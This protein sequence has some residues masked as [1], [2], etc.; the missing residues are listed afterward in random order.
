MALPADRQAFLF[1]DI[2]KLI[3]MKLRSF[4]T[5]WLLKDGLIYTYPSLQE[6]VDCDVLIVGGGIT[7]ALMAFQLSGEGYKTILIDKR[8]VSLG[9]TS[10]TTAMIQYELDEPLHSLIEKV[11]EAAAVDTYLA[12]VEAIRQ[13]DALI[14]MLKI[15]CGFASKKSLFVSRRPEHDVWLKKEYECRKFYGLEVNRLENGD[16]KKD[17]DIAGCGGLLSDA[18]ASL[19]AYRLAH[20]LI[21]HAAASQNLRVYDHTELKETSWNGSYHSVLTT[22]LQEIRCVSIVYATGF[23]T[24]GFIKEKIVELNSTFACVSEPMVKV[25]EKLKNTI[26]WDTNDPYLYI[27]TTSDNR[28]L[29]GGEDELFEHPSRRDNMIDEKEEGLVRGFQKL[30]PSMAFVPDFTWAG[31]FGKTKDSLPY[32]GVKNDF[33]NS[34]FVLGF[35]GNGITFSVMGMKIISDA[36]SGKPNKFLDYFKF[37]R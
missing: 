26:V 13:L 11:G 27:R 2:S 34:Y 21:H 4:E 19:D 10:A 5:Y 16:L 32:I 1:S 6:D 30:M 22:N 35:G 12:G 28:I 29:V 3:S 8:D 37:G 31:T 25:T 9:S 20:G 14:S 17:Y 33:P 15:D 36:M 18:G 23:E 7:G 24:Q